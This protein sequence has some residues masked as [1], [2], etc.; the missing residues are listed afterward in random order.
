MGNKISPDLK[1]RER[2]V[3]REIL[4]DKMN[5][6]CPQNASCMALINGVLMVRKEQGGRGY[7]S[8]FEKKV[9]RVIRDLRT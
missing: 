7:I 2:Q 8:R 4:Q 9:P 3:D 5:S 6:K 1:D